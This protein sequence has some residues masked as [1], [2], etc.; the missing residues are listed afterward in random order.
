MLVLMILI[1]RILFQEQEVIEKNIADN[2]KSAEQIDNLKQW[3]KWLIIISVILLIGGFI[4]FDLIA[5]RLA[6][7]NQATIACYQQ[8]GKSAT[9]IAGAGITRLFR[10]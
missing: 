4:S 1:L 5:Q 3:R 6:E 8:A 9:I 2:S 7:A 10:K